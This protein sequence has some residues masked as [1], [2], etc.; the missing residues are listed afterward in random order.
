MTMLAECPD[1]QGSVSIRALACP[2]CGAPGPFGQDGVSETSTPVNDQSV[3][4]QSVREEPV[5]WQNSR[6][7][8]AL[9]QR[10]RKVETITL[11]ETF[12][13]CR[14][15]GIRIDYRD[16][17]CIIS[18]CKSKSYNYLPASEIEG[19]WCI[20]TADGLE[21]PFEFL[22]FFGGVKERTHQW[23]GLMDATHRLIVPHVVDGVLRRIESGEEVKLLFFVL[24]R[25]GVR[26]TRS[27]LF[28]SDQERLI[29]WCEYLGMGE[30]ATYNVLES[31]IFRKPEREKDR[32][33]FC[34][35]S[36]AMNL[37]DCSFMAEHSWPKFDW[38]NWV[39]LPHVLHACAAK[40]GGCS[41]TRF[42]SQVVRT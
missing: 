22:G 37:D 35:P 19:L 33:E 23:S 3:N 30:F 14:E 36:V 29:P 28:R 4:D 27:R 7:R 11:H 17:T 25:E 6:K 20:C 31:T 41:F 1:C 34:D 40:Y 38:P 16:V 12:A 39:V 42:S 26:W 18:T 15:K 32:S 9:R 24:T 10:D 13:E 8:L 2:H 21:L 5:V